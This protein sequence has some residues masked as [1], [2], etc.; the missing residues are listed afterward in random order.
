MFVVEPVPTDARPDYVGDRFSLRFE[1]LQ[2]HHV[3]RVVCWRC[4]RAGAVYSSR[5][6]HLSPY[7]KLRSLETRFR[8]A[9]CRGRGATAYVYMLSRN[10]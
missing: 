6:R 7:T 8:C 10:T 4:G 2:E 9:G 5:L 3:L 1:D